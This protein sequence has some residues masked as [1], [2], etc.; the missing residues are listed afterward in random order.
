MEAKFSRTAYYELAEFIEEGEGGEF[1]LLV[2][3]KKYRIAH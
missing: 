1:F 2:N 3:E